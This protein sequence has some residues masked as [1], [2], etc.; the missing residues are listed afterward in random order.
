M[1]SDFARDG[2]VDFARFARFTGHGVAED[3]GR[4]AGCAEH[5]GG[6][7]KALVCGGDDVRFGAREHGGAGLGG[8]GDVTTCARFEMRTHADRHAAIEF[9]ED[10]ECV[11]IGTRVGHG[12]AA[13][14][15][16]WFVAG[17]IRDHQRDDARFTHRGEFAALYQRQVFA[18]HVHVL[19]RRAAAQ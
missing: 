9:G 15:V 13:G 8:F 10:V 19:N 5:F 14:D 3:D 1:R 2:G 11:L 18:H 7:F 12:G 16:G 4:D 6:S 17:H